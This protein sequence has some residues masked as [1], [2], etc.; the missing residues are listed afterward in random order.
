[1]AGARSQAQLVIDE[2]TAMA[3]AQDD[4][5]AARRAFLATG[6]SIYFF[7]NLGSLAGALAGGG[8]DDPGSLGLDVMFPAAFLALLAPQ[9]RR[10]G[11]PTAA[12]GGALIAV[13]LVPV[14]PTGV[15]I[16]ATALAVVPVIALRR[17]RR[18]A[19]VA[20]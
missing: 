2:S 16:M 3:R 4:P 12:L 11:A 13:V 17:R 19:E 8:L 1:M 5:R 15:P 14:A 10:P 9:L 7:W 6:L 20:P 18:A